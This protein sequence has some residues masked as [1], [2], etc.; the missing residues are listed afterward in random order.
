MSAETT[1][2]QAKVVEPLPGTSTQKVPQ[3]A[4]GDDD[5]ALAPQCGHLSPS[6]C[7]S[8]S[9][10]MTPHLFGLQGC[11]LEY[12]YRKAQV[13]VLRSFISA[14]QPYFHFLESNGRNALFYDNKNKH[15]Q[16]LE[17]S[18]EM[19]DKLECLV[20]KFATREL[21]T[22]DDSDPENSM[23]HFRIGHLKVKQLKLKVTSFR[24]CKPTPYLARVNTGIFKR[25]RWN[26]EPYDSSINT[27]SKYY[28]MCCEKIPNHADSDKLHTKDVQMWSIGQWV[29]VKPDPNTESI[30]DWVLCDVPEGAFEKL[31]DLGKK[32]PSSSKATDHLLQLLASKENISL[33][34]SQLSDPLKYEE[35][36]ML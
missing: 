21:V 27:P 6:C 33:D 14:C 13:G 28:Y 35:E 24:Y 19:C 29:Q 2:V 25:M 20:L 3:V 30:F 4:C 36:M 8:N 10:S 17:L 32:E 9:P 26:V 16:L 12:E 11:S 7:K 22:L 18:Q 15:E 31:L 1:D 23:A 5:E 34:L